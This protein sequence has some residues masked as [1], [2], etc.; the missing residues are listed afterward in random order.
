M[1]VIYRLGETAVQHFVADCVQ[2]QLFEHQLSRYGLPH[3][4]ILQGHLLG[5][6]IT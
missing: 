6:D 2:Y 5:K 1:D 4:S 3:L